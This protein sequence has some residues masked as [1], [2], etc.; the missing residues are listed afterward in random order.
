[1]RQHTL[2][3]MAERRSLALACIRVRAGQRVFERFLKG[4]SLTFLPGFPERLFI[5]NRPC[6]NQYSH[7]H[8]VIRLL[9]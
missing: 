3:K 1:M 2:F 9:M 4:H 7:N 8:T 5:Q 6:L